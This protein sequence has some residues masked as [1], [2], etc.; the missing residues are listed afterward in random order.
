MFRLTTGG[1]L[2][3]LL[4][5]VL[6][7]GPAAAQRERGR[8]P[9]TITVK[10]DYDVVDQDDKA[11]EKGTFF[12]RGFAIFNKMNKRIGT[13]EDVSETEVKVTI[14]EGKLKGTLDLTKE[15]PTSLTWK[16]VLERGSG[17][18]YKISVVFEKIK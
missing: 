15:K 2:V 3:A 18:T 4:T 5:G 17:L 8:T 13:Y 7:S 6:V 1:M 9:P 14:T 16:G 10:W 11:V 12:A